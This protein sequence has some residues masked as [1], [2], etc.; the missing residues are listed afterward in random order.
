VKLER[1]VGKVYS[2]LHCSF[3]EV[4]LLDCDNL[5]LRD[6]LLLFDDPEYLA[7]GNL[8]WPDA[9][10]NWVSREVY[11]V[12]GLRYPEAKVRD[13]VALPLRLGH[14]FKKNIN[15]VRRRSVQEHG[16]IHVLKG[17]IG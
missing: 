1:W 15:I 6:P 2:L 11:S 8:F 5:P 14:A 3:Q 17:R 4:L 7:N 13:L 16:Q 10:A 12:V 9:W